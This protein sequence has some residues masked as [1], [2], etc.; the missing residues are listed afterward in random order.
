MQK[1]KFFEEQKKVFDGKKNIFTKEKKLT[2]KKIFLRGK[3]IFCIQKFFCVDPCVT[4][5]KNGVF[6]Y[7][8]TIITSRS[9]T[10]FTMVEE[11]F[12]F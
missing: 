5:I 10:N 4:C 7:F 6:Y 12:E 11:K 3:K 1:K 8:S 9:L 2:A